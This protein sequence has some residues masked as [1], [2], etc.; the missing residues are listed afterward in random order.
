[1]LTLPSDPLV[2]SLAEVRPNDLIRVEHILFDS[3][4][5]ECHG[6]GIAEGDVLRCRRSSRAVL[7]L[8]TSAGRTL[9]LDSDWARFIQV[10]PA[11]ST[12]QALA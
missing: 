9:I 8:E 11:E 12:Q 7:L 2:R 1:M 5:E 4:R 3:L 10:R 6:I